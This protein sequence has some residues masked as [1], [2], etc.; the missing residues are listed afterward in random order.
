[1]E[2]EFTRNELSHEDIAEQMVRSG[3]VNFDALGKFITQLGP[4]L[5][6]KDKGWHGV[7][8]GR[9]NVLACM[10]PAVDLQRMVGNI[11]AGGLTASTLEKAIEASLPG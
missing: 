6:V 9:Y 1:M 10:M 2:P 5:A 11:R 3:V 4:V 8:F 7:N